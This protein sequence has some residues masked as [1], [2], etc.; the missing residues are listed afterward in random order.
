M[1][2]GRSIR[3]ARYPSIHVSRDYLIPHVCI[4]RNTRHARRSHGAF[5]LYSAIW[6]VGGG[7]T[8]NMCHC[9]LCIGY[10]K[11]VR[12]PSPLPPFPL[13]PNVN[14]NVKRIYTYTPLRGSTPLVDQYTFLTKLLSSVCR[15]S[16]VRDYEFSVA[17]YM[18]CMQR[19]RSGG[20]G[21][22]PDYLR[23]TDS[24]LLVRLK[25]LR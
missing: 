18:D 21:V 3:F 22:R 9:I 23:H 10:A 12:S 2:S 7:R 14:V 5:L 1:Q 24:P 17:E 6:W 16:Q 19:R 25:F 8:L 4:L 13:A 11:L 20:E 15:I